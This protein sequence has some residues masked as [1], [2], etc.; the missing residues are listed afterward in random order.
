MSGGVTLRNEAGDVC[1]EDFGIATV[2]STSCT[3]K[4]EVS[5]LCDQ[6]QVSVEKRKYLML[7]GGGV[8]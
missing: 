3:P 7:Q 2:S 5:C 6:L 1:R 8:T 4:D